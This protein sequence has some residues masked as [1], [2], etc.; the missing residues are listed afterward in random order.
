MYFEDYLLLFGFSFSIA[1]AIYI[2]WKPE[3]RQD[4]EPICDACGQV[5]TDLREGL[6]AWCTNFYKANK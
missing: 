1:L 5:T 2:L 4:G 3:K 6:C